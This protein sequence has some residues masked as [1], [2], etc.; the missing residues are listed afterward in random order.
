MRLPKNAHV[1]IVDGENFSVMRNSGAPLEP[2]LPALVDR[3]AVWAGGGPVPVGVHG[4]RKPGA[5]VGTASCGTVAA[6][7]ACRAGS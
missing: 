1:A 6:A 3:V 5:G 4:T 2:K 7:A